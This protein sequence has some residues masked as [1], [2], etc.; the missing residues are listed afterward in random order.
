VRTPVITGVGVVSS[1]GVGLREY[2][3]ALAEGRCGI[4][5]VSVFNTSG[6]KGTLGAEVRGLDV[7]E[8]VRWCNEFGVYFRADRISRCDAIGLLAAAEALDAA[9]FDSGKVSPKRIAVVLG[10]GGGGLLS[11]EAYRKQLFRHNRPRPSLLVPFTS[12]TFADK[13]ALLTGSKGMRSTVSTACS[14]SATAVGIAAGLIREGRADVVITGGSEALSETTFSGFNSLRAVDE[15]PCRPFDLNRGGIS[16][17]EGSGIFVIEALEE[18]MFNGEPIAQVGG[19][20]LTADAYHATAP[21]PD[22]KCVAHA[23]E[24][25]VMLSGLTLDDIGYINAHGTGT[26]ANDEAETNAIKSAFGEKARSIPV[27]STKSMIGHCLGAAGALE[28]AASLLPLV[29]GIVPP[30]VNY[31]TPD[32]ACDLD[33]VPCTSRRVPGIHSVLSTSLAFGGNNTAIVLGRIA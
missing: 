33:Y 7:Q 8:A 1:I 11:G 26:K 3:A 31:E 25:A 19:Y 27:S 4:G 24:D 5:E 18:R 2:W 6:F 12:G 29:E 20:G 32:P 21:A 15:V 30:T 16:L 9:K 14:S 10:S 17:G 13:I 28:V 22:G 23:I